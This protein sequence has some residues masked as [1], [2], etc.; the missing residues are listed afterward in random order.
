MKNI[1]VSFKFI[2]E[3]GCKEEKKIEYKNTHKNILYILAYFEIKFITH[4]SHC[5]V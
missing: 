2:P 1:F 3:N 4:K 5:K